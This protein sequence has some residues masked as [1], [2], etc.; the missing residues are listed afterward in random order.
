MKQEYSS[1]VMT[2]QDFSLA[3]LVCSRGI[4]CHKNSS[5]NVDSHVRELLVLSEHWATTQPSGTH[6]WTHKKRR[7]LPAT[8]KRKRRAG[9]KRAT[10]TTSTPPRKNYEAAHPI[11][12]N[13]PT[14]KA[15]LPRM[16]YAE[17]TRKYLLSMLV[18]CRNK[19]QP[20]SRNL[21]RSR[22]IQDR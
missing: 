18:S 11:M 6:A 7:Q 17:K 3:L 15:K 4:S 20:Q 21:D 5:N 22:D 14:T 2:A 16:I 8:K 19:T 1:F 12:H 9:K 10:I 13:I